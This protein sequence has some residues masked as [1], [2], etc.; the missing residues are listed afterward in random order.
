MY[1]Y[2]TFPSGGIRDLV[3]QS[4]HLGNHTNVLATKCHI[5]N[6]C[7]LWCFKNSFCLAL[8][9]SLL[10]HVLNLKS[11]KNSISSTEKLIKYV[12]FST[13]SVKKFTSLVQGIQG[14]SK[15]STIHGPFCQIRNTFTFF[16]LQSF[17]FDQVRV[18]VNSEGKGH[19]SN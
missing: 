1:M 12:R 18:M 3:H 14:L 15:S 13:I 10:C 5:P 6:I 4:R 9:C 7:R 11:F 19:D 8:P 17:S 16:F 2:I